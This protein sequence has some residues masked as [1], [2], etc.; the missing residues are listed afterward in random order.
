MWYFTNQN[1]LELAGCE[2]ALPSGA[3]AVG[4]AVANVGRVH[5]GVDSV[6][7]TLYVGGHSQQAEHRHRRVSVAEWL[8][9]NQNRAC[10]VCTSK[11]AERWHS[12]ALHVTCTPFHVPEQPP[13]AAALPQNSTNT[14]NTS[15]SG[16]KQAAALHRPIMISRIDRKHYI[17]ARKQSRVA[18][19]WKSGWCAKFGGQ[20]G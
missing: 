12:P 19:T 16:L 7:D 1:E 18:D 8:Q 5:S 15:A 17:E 14:T 10:F 9:G 6:H 3:H 11:G 2:R 4:H 20:Y 13:E